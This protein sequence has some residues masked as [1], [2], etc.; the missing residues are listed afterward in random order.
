M[1]CATPGLSCKGVNVMLTAR[2]RYLFLIFSL[3][4]MASG[5]FLSVGVQ[6]NFGQV[7]MSEFYIQADD[8]SNIFTT[9]QRPLY[10][11]STDPLPGVVVIHGSLQNKEWLMA[12]GIELARR[13]FVVMTIDANGHGNS[14]PGTGSGKAALDYLA[15]QDFV[16]ES[17]MG[18]IGHSM[19]GGISW[20]AIRESSTVVRALV[21]VGAGVPSNIS[22]VP[23]IPNLLVTVGDFDSLSRYPRNTSRLE[24]AFGVSDIQIGTTYGDFNTNTARKY[25]LTKTNHLFET[26]D[27]VIVTESVEWMKDSL[28]SGV[29]DEY[30]I[31]SDQQVY[32]LWLAGGFIGV[33]GLVL[34]VLPL[35]AILLDLSPFSTLKAEPEPTYNASTKSYLGYGIL[36]G[37]LGVG[38]FFPLLGVGLAI[39]AFIDFP[40]RWGVAVMSWILGTG[41]IAALILYIILRAKLKRVEHFRTL[42]GMNEGGDVILRRFLR[43]FL[44]GVIIFAW[45]YLWTLIVDIGLLLD[46]RSFLPGFNDLTLAQAMLVPLY[47]IVYLVYFSVE[48]MWLTGVLRGAPKESVTRTQIDW[49]IRAIFIK[50]LPYLILIAFEYGGGLLTGTALVPGLIGY[51]F[52]FFY[53]FTPWFAVTSILILW[54]YRHTNSHYLGAIVSA[55]MCAWLMASILAI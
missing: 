7:E 39:D 18:L 12:F 49:T 30:W 13:G 46:F 14:D 42:A 5:I 1:T 27:S 11:T 9:L 44:F 47:F 16:D 24:P 54:S 28:K 48:G 32:G 6:R 55:L 33:L 37:V 2:Q 10:A 36:Y 35:I 41:L 52:L 26:I 23:Y 50:C 31:P 40:Q 45:L 3:I 17:E 29:E 51:S 8:G 22:T 53:A 4:L 43:L 38:L 20:S 34:S 25:V 21:L 15:A 19:G